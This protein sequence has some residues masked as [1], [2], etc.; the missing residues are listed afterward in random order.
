M[1][2]PSIGGVSFTT[3]HGRVPP[4]ATADEV[5]VRPGVDGH[6][7]IEIGARGEPTILRT[8]RDFDSAAAAA[9]HIDTCAA[10]QA[11]LVTVNYSDGTSENNVQIQ[12]VVPA[13]GTRYSPVS[14]GGLTAGSW[15]VYLEWTV[16]QAEYISSGPFFRLNRPVTGRNSK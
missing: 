6:E 1:A 4:L 16:F 14:V 8:M 2:T 3:L 7:L 11:T 10:L 5:K 13:G 15:R 12:R 9:S